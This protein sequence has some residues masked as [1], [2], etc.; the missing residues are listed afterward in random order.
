MSL[1]NLPFLFYG[2]ALQIEP[3]AGFTLVLIIAP[4]LAIGGVELPSEV[5][6]NKSIDQ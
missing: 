3:E 4:V 1:A 6:S 5:M 2:L